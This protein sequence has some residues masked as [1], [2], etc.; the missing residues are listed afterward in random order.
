MDLIRDFR[1]PDAA[2][3]LSCRIHDE[4]GSGRFKIMEV[5]GGQ[6]HTIYKYRLKEL[7]PEGL[8]L[9]SGP[10]LLYKLY[11]LPGLRRARCRSILACSCTDGGAHDSETDAGPGWEAARPYL[12]A[13][14]SGR[15]YGQ[16]PQSSGGPPR[17][18][19]SRDG[20]TAVLDQR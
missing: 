7:L 16:N 1:D 6:T 17:L 13:S 18:P 15:T 10:G 4:I 8:T 12:P 5:C 20:G 11:R 14:S 3:Q 2:R 9:V 19:R